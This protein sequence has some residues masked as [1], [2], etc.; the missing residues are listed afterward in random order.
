MKREIRNFI[1]GI[2]GIVILIICLYPILWLVISSFK[3]NIEINTTPSYLPPLHWNFNNYVRA[4][5]EG[6]IGVFL[7]NSLIATISSMILVV[8]LA[9]PLSFA[10]AKM[11]WRFKE[12]VYSIFSSGIMIPTVIVLLPLFSLYKKLNLINTLW[13][14]ILTYTSFGL[15]L[16]MYIMTSFIKKIPDELIE[17]AI[18]DGASIYKVFYSIMLPLMRTPIITVL[19]LQFYN[20]WNDLIFSMTFISS[21]EKKTIQTGL[22]YFTSMYS[23][24]D[25]GCI[26]AAV[27]ISILPLVIIYTVLNRSIIEGMTMGAIKG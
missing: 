12:L 9:T 17:A 24:S 15:A 5:T 18:V 1:T 3:S 16:S 19:V 4:W 22:L 6:K 20:R 2:I 27:S 26:F 7:K 13:S 8:L 11:N 14:L 21:A 10:L 23:G 25:W